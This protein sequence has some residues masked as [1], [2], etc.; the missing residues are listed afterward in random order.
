MLPSCNIL[1]TLGFFRRGRGREGAPHNSVV[2]SDNYN[3]IRR[4]HLFA[5]RSPMKL[6]RPPKK[7]ASLPTARWNRVE[8]YNSGDRFF[9][10]VERALAEAQR[11]IDM[12]S[13]IFALDQA[14]ER[15]LRALE[16]ATARGVRVRL[17]VDGI[18]S[19]TWTRA[20]RERAKSGGILF[21]VYHELPWER[22]RRGESLG[23]R[24]WGLSRI[25]QRL[26]TRN[27]R[28]V[29]IIDG[30]RAFV[31]SMNVSACHLSTVVGSAAWRDTGVLVEGPDVGVLRDSFEE[32][33]TRSWRRLRR[34]FKRKRVQSNELV[35]LNVRHRERQ[36]HYLDLLV[37]IVRAQQR[38]WI[39]NAYFVPDGSLLRALTIAAQADVDVRILVP[40][41]SDIVF[42]PWIASAFQLG[43][44]RAGVKIFE[45]Q[46]SILHAKTM[47]VD[48][49]ALVGSSNL[50]HRS[51]LHDLEA[52]V[53]VADDKARSSLEEQFLLDCEQSEQVTLENWRRRSL[54]E[55]F[56]GRLLLAFRY[57]L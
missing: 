4:R 24:K 53:V 55:R 8:V 44:L 46:R 13:Y 40:R 48:D 26:N 50:N 33:W 27:H 35:R 54:I 19:S 9:E 14:G 47:L 41:F 31:G 29:C 3:C 10:D 38:V 37:R 20:L 23:A 6:L 1:K 5:F 51:L 12:E 21:K 30:M 25:L 11:T 7:T 16:G 43:L 34:R 56:L 45:Y 15:V 49:W 42:M 36:S 18:G 22:W 32:V 2:R 52:D 28:K 39:T 57:L 17:A